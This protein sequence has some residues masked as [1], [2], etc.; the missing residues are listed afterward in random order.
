MTI[1]FTPTI[2]IVP[3]YVRIYKY[4]VTEVSVFSKNVYMN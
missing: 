1:S 2:Q 4:E 3:H